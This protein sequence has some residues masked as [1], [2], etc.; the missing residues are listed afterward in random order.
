MYPKRGQN[1]VFCEEGTKTSQLFSEILEKDP[2]LSEL[3]PY[4]G[5]FGPF[6]AVFIEILFKIY[7]RVKLKPKNTI[8][9]TTTFLGYIGDLRFIAETPTYTS[10]FLIHRVGS[11]GG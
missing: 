8:W 3:C 5:K 6:L 4:M 10:M 9:G 2:N 11:G 1:E 7:T